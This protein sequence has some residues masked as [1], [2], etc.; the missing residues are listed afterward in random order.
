MGK[1]RCPHCGSNDCKEREKTFEKVADVAVEFGI[2]AVKS[3]FTGGRMDYQ[4][5]MNNAS[6]K[7]AFKSGL[8]NQIRSYRCKTCGYTWEG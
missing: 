5:A 3:I 4:K 8:N 6:S 2:Q 7:A 1:I